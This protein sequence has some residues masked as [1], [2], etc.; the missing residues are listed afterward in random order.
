MESTVAMGN[1]KQTARRLGLRG[2]VLGFVLGVLALLVCGC[3]ANGWAHPGETS[4]EVHRRH[5]RVMTLNQ[6][7]MLADIDRI[8]GLD[9]PSRLTELR[10]P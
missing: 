9:E 8:L 7:E 6:Q 2:L 5:K 4:A 3:G 10:I 1:G